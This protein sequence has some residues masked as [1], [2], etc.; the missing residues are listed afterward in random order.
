MVCFYQPTPASQLRRHSVVLITEDKVHDHHAV[1]AFTELA[2]QD[3]K[4]ALAPIELKK[5]I[6]SLVMAA[7]ASREGDVC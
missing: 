4:K 6:P 5:K 7:S 2:V 1:H 3:L